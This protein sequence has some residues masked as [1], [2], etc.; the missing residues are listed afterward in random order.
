ME[1]G[2]R[3]GPRPDP[4]RPSPVTANSVAFSPDGKLLAAAYSDGTVWLWNRAT[5]EA[6]A[7]TPPVS[8]PV[9]ANS[10]AF[11]PDGKL[12]AGAY[13]NG[14]IGFGTRRPARPPAPSPRAGREPE[15]ARTAWRSDPA[16]TC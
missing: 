13:G 8:S 4:A 2:D 14:T 9:T 11:S 15:R 7:L 1:P 5:G 6:R 16:A 10:L 12:L 3:P